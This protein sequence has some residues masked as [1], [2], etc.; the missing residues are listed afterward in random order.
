MRF[1]SP[2]TDLASA[3]ASEVLPVPGM[4]SSRTCPPEKRALIISFISASLPNMTLPILLP[5]ACARVL[6]S[7]IS[8][9]SLL[10]Y[11]W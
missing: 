2:E 3:R 6:T 4:S 9:R 1:T 7:R 5:I 11:N 8:I 10:V